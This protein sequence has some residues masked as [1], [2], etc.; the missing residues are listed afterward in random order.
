[1][2]SLRSYLLPCSSLYSS[3]VLAA[4]A[5]AIN[6]VSYV[7]F[8]ETCPVPRKWDLRCTGIQQQISLED[9]LL[10]RFVYPIEARMSQRALADLR[11]ACRELFVFG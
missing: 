1:M 6:I 10:Y 3:Q 5:T 11:R 9:A 4:G 2:R 8:F 7:T